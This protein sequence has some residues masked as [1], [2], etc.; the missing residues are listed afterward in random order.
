MEGH[1]KIYL[2]SAQDL[3]SSIYCFKKVKSSSQCP[4]LLIFES[5]G[6]GKISIRRRLLVKV[7]FT[8]M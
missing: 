7:Y 3:Q 8:F 1:F 4:V 6:K 5:D 2:P